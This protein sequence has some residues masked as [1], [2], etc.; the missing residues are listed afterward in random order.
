MRRHNRKKRYTHPRILILCEGETE[1]KYFKGILQDKDFKVR[2]SGVR[3]NI[4]VSKAS[5]SLRLVKEAIKRRKV[6][7]KEGNSFKEVW[8]IFDHDNHPNH[9]DAWNLAHTNQLNIGFSAIAF[10]QWFLLHFSK[11]AK[12]F[13]TPKLLEKELLKFYPVYRKGQQND[14]A[15]LK[16]KME[17]AFSNANWLRGLKIPEN[18]LIPDQNPWVDVDFL[19]KK[20][21]TG[22]F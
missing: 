12:A 3:V 22:K 16:D 8:V 2:L 1:E 15:F 4:F 9:K 21:I 14:F 17:V 7:K 11:S 20:L 13:S 10:E 18:I 6:A 19:V 5:D